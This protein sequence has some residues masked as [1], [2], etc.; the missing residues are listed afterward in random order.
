MFPWK[1]SLELTPHQAV[2]SQPL[3]KLF[4][5]DLKMEQISQFS[6]FFEIFENLV[7]FRTREN[8]HKVMKFQISF[9]P[10][11]HKLLASF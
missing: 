6:L 9:F 5:L 10:R 3:Q 8:N 7:E 1:T 2:W 11:K 4:F